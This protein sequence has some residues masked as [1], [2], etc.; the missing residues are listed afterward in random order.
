MTQL[1]A[2]I[3]GEA[4]G[5]FGVSV[6]L[7]HGDRLIVGADANDGAGSM[8]VMQSSPGMDLPGVNWEA[9][10]MARHQVTDL[11]SLSILI[12]METEWP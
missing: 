7:I 4:A 11:D 1:G 8:Q 9:T 10:S 6:A 5:S 3:D 12:L 2:D